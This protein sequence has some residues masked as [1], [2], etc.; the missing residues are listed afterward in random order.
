M[1]DTTFSAKTL[2]A[3]ETAGWFPGR[4]VEPGP[5]TAA[6]TFPMVRKFLEQFEGL[7]IRYEGPRV[8]GRVDE[9]RIDP[10][11]AAKEIDTKWVKDYET[12]VGCALVP[13]GQA[14][15]R[16]ATLLMAPDGRVW[17]GYDDELFPLGVSGEDAIENICTGEAYK[18]R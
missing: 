15:S 6:A 7:K 8:T 5:G 16:H 17:G 11:I 13:I 2:T 18:P 9:I 4:K 10:T 12:R 1:H 14:F 3:L